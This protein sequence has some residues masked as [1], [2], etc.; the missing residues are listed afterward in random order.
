MARRRLVVLATAVAFLAAAGEALAVGGDYVFVGGSPEAQEQVRAAIDRSSFDF[1]VVPARIT[2]R[3]TNCGCAGAKPGEIV[4]DEVQLTSSPFG[5]RYAW[6]LVQDEYA[7]QVDFFVL[8]ARDRRI[9]RR[10]IGGKAWC[11]EVPGL[12]HDDY[13]CERFSTLLAWA[14]WRSPD[15]V[16][17]P[18]WPGGPGMTRAEFRALLG[19]LLAG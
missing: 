9:L 11:Y 16:R 18:S 7:H 17:R 12:A 19:R 10:N 4:L 3:I 8:G 2:I 1:D 13:G 5:A 15:N 6:G 14:Y